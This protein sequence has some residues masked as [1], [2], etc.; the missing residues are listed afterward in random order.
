MGVQESKAVQDSVVSLAF[1][2]QEVILELQVH[3][4]QEER[5]DQLAQ[6]VHQELL[7]QLVKQAQQDQLDH[8]G[9]TAKLVNLVTLVQLDTQDL[10]VTRVKEGSLVKG[11]SQEKQVSLDLKDPKDLLDLGVL[12]ERQA[13]E[14]PLVQLELQ[15]PFSLVSM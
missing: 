10:L 13:K 4:D 2:V 12:K 3:L 15:V 6:E 1:K 8:A 9:Q 5:Q 14:V 7:A 11:A